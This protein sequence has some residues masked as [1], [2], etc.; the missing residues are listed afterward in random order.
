[1]ARDHSRPV[2]PARQ[3]LLR[4]EV[5]S[6][7]RISPSI[8]RLTIG[9]P[10][11]DRFAPMGHDQ[12]FRFFFPRDGQDS[13]RL[14]G[15]GDMLGYAQFLATP[16]SVRPHM[17][18]YSARAVRRTPDGTQ[19]DIDFVLHEGGAASTWVLGAATGA[20]VAVLDEGVGFDPPADAAWFLLSGDETSIP[21]IAGICASLP[22]DARGIAFVEVPSRDDAQS[23][24]TPAGL[25]VRWLAREEGERASTLALA[26]VRGADLPTGVGYAFSVGEAAL[27]TGVRRH[28][29]NERG[30]AKTHV[31]FCGYWRHA[32]G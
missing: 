18:N 21:A 10:E 12:W 2:K 29:V 11:L 32:S 26:A 23:F 3:E 5:V 1:M 4:A 28:L 25:D 27:A 30:F 8:A 31:A 14:P 24:E 16:K 6:V 17:R 20:S 13:F 15:R 7:T 22:A 19:L 9:G